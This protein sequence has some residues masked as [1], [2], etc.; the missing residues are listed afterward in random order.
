MRKPDGRFEKANLIC[1]GSMTLPSPMMSSR[2]SNGSIRTAKCFDDLYDSLQPD[3]KDFFEFLDG[4]VEKVEVFYVARQGDAIRRAHEL[5]SQLRELAE[6]RKLYHELYPEGLPQ[7]EATVERYIPAVAVA[8]STNWSDAKN[9][10]SRMLGVPEPGSGP[11]GQ[12]PS[13]G[14]KESAG[15]QATAEGPATAAAAREREA[16][17][18]AMLA[19]K[20]HVEYSPERYRKYK[21]ELRKA[22]LEFYR[23]L[24][25]IKNYRVGLRS[26]HRS[27]QDMLMW[28]RS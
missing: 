3:E 15:V 11:D 16:L 28:G 12:G 13:A 22:V 20:D 21:A 17:K 8:R 4:Q 5:R 1:A 7:W 25:L 10:M 18:Q 19:D 26:A 6:H 27:A 24:E 9:R 23:Q 14:G 2:Q